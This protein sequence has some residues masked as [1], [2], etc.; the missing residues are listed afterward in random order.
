M[1][2]K[3]IPP[4]VAV[5]PTKDLSITVHKETF[6]SSFLWITIIFSALLLILIGITIYFAY[7]QTR[8]GPIPAPIQPTVSSTLRDNF[9]AS[10]EITTLSRELNNKSTQCNGNGVL[11]NDKCEC[12]PSFIGLSCSIQKHDRRYYAVGNADNINA[13]IIEQFNT[14]NKSFTEESCSNRCD[15]LSDCIGF[16]YDNNIC[17]L[18]KDKVVIPVNS[19]LTYSE[20][21]DTKLYL[22]SP[23][24]LHFENRIFLGFNASSLL[25]RY[26]LLDN[27]EDYIQIRPNKIYKLNFLPNY[28]RMY[29]SYTGIYCT[30]KFTNRDVNIIMN[31]GNTNES[32]IHI[33]GTHIKLPSSWQYKTVYVVYI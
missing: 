11:I 31:R 3:T 14:Q 26:W 25:P 19:N 32:N 12:I 9:G 4:Y 24:T 13:S 21:E 29:E 16:I 2:S 18:L 10:G 22:L 20:T 1:E 6:D 33:S 27:T 17:T 23:D 8:F 7:H 15:N 5:G 30:Y 28:T